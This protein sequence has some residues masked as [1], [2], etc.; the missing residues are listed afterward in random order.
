M[1]QIFLDNLEKVKE[2]PKMKGIAESVG[3]LYE[4]CERKVALEGKIGRALGIGAIGAMGALGLNHVAGNPVDKALDSAKETAAEVKADAQKDLNE[5]LTTR[6]AQN[7]AFYGDELASKGWTYVDA[8]SRPGLYSDSLNHVALSDIAKAPAAKVGWYVSPDRRTYYST[9]TG[10][11]FRMPEGQTFDDA[12][13]ENPGQ[14]V[15]V[16]TAATGEVD[17]DPDECNLKTQGMTGCKDPT[18]MTAKDIDWV[19]GAN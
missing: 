18:L 9:V 1:N 13:R 14:Q 5:D 11:V 4:A 2:N 10:K 15:G 17:Y 7:Y 16:G 12:T 19:R 3:K 8:E 6:K